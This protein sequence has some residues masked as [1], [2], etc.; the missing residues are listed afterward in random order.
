T[1][2]VEDAQ[3]RELGLARARVP[4][5]R[6]MARRG[7]LEIQAYDEV[8]VPGLAAEWAKWGGQRPF[9]G[10]L[11]M[12]LSTESDEQVASW[13]ASGTPPICFATGSIP[14]ESPSETVE[15]IASACSRL[16]ER[17]LICAGG[18]DVSAVP[19]F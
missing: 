9:V 4:S 17:A 10:A 14:V 11:T 1:R 15:M 13:I 19:E 6:R 12:G 18:T 5:A 16:G 3:R 8:S 7:V 2:H